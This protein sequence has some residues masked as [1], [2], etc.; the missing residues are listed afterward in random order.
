MADKAQAELKRRRRNQEKMRERKQRMAVHYTLAWTAGELERERD[1]QRRMGQEAGEEATGSEAD[2]IRVTWRTGYAGIRVG[3]AAVPG[4][5]KK[6]ARTQGGGK[7]KPTAWESKTAAR[8][9]TLNK[10][11]T[12]KGRQMKRELMRNAIR[13]PGEDVKAFVFIYVLEEEVGK[14]LDEPERTDG[15]TGRQLD[16]GQRMLKELT[17]GYH[18]RL[19]R[20]D[21]Q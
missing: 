19:Q 11:R 12:E 21:L 13:Q 2:S 10:E 8:K 9:A 14:A 7:A 4:P 17:K 3:E 18:E 6:R 1:R 15:R 20:A 5:P 16:T